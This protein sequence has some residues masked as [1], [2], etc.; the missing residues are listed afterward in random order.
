[1]TKTVH[2]VSGGPEGPTSIWDLREFQVLH[3]VSEAGFMCQLGQA[4]FPTS[5]GNFD[6]H[7]KSL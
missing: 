2:D 6:E 3:G 1:M 7:R 4:E 5:G